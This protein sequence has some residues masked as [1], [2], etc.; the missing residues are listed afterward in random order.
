M[1]LVGHDSVLRG[2]EVEGFGIPHG[3]PEVISFEPEYELEDVLIHGGI[4]A[5]ETV[6]GPTA[7]R[8]VLIVDENATVPDARALT[9]GACSDVNV[10]ALFNRDIRE[11]VPR[12]DADLFGEAVGAENSTAT[13][14]AHDDE[15][16][17]HAGPGPIDDLLAEAL[18]LVSE[19]SGIQSAGVD[20]TVEDGALAEH[21]DDNSGAA[22]VCRIVYTVRRLSADPLEVRREAVS[23]SSNARIRGWVCQNE[24]RLRA[25]N[26]A[27]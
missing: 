24:D 26:Q 18:P 21:A 22:N 5:P 23:R 1:H 17:C 4:D 2:I 12:R 9:A 3:R 20:Q 27:E 19:I 10:G 11:P 16:L 14:G 6:L 13:I 8:R 15:R 7:E 25:D